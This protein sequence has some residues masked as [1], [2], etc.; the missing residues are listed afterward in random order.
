MNDYLI[1]PRD[2]QL[3]AQREA[4]A[5]LGAPEGAAKLAEAKRYGVLADKIDR[6]EAAVQLCEKHQ[7]NGGVRAQCVIC[8]GEALSAA[9]S[10]ISYL[11]S[12]PNE[13]EVSPY[14]IHFD[15]DA[16]VDQ[17]RRALSTIPPT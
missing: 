7:P 17:V 1:T 15:E 2:W 10:K 13:M 4:A 12:D 8:S 16:V 5:L 11:C 6:L 3:I 9:L 14:D